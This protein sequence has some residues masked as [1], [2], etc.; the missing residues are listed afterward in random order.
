LGILI[1][2]GIFIYCTLLAA[3]IAVTRLEKSDFSRSA[4]LLFVLLCLTLLALSSQIY[5]G[6]HLLLSLGKQPWRQVFGFVQSSGRAFWAVG[7]VISFAALAA[8]ERMRRR[9]AVFLLVLLSGMQV[10]DTSLLHGAEREAFAGPAQPP[11]APAELPLKTVVLSEALPCFKSPL[12]DTDR[13]RLQAVRAG[14]GLGYMRVPRAPVWFNC[15]MGVADGT[16]LPIEPNET[17]IMPLALDQ[18]TLPLR[19]SVF[20]AGAVCRQS[21]GFW[22]C[23]L[24]DSAAAGGMPAVHKVPI[25]D[26]PYSAEAGSASQALSVGGA[27]PLG[28]GWV[29]DS[30]GVAW[31]DGPRSTLV[32]RLMAPSLAGHDLHLTLDVTPIGYSAQGARDLTITLGRGAGR[33]VRLVDGVSTQINLPINV[34]DLLGTDLVRIAFDTRYPVDP[35]KRGITAPVKRA[36]IAVHRIKLDVGSGGHG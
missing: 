17:R 30:Q 2:W 29:L 32:F 6:H 7:Y 11:A 22:L 36:A 26:A 21:A 19:D 35:V 33:V 8:F 28:L 27:S 25:L 20:D 15:A 18:T 31:S 12:V 13:L 34:S 3:A 5:V 4:G 14:I 1:C 24:H 23:S 10:L 16:E 9:Q